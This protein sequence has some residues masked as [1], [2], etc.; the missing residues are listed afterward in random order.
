MVPDPSRRLMRDIAFMVSEG[1]GPAQSAIDLWSRV[2]GRPPPEPT[3]RGKVV[4]AAFVEWM[5]GFPPGWVDDIL[6]NRRA[7]RLLGNAVVPHQSALALRML[8]APP[9]QQQPRLPLPPPV[10]ALASAT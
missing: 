1:W 5:M 4:S 3:R 9:V 10:T 7:L 2:I 8:T 6:P